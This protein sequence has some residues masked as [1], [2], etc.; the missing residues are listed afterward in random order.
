MPWKQAREIVII[1]SQYFESLLDSLDQKFK[2]EFLMLDIEI[3]SRLSVAFGG[4]T[5]SPHENI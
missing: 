5:V 1:R 2:R 3:L 4:N